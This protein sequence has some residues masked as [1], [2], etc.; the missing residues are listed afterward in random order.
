M[1]KIKRLLAAMLTLVMLLQPF[2]YAASVSEFIDFP[3]DWSSE[4]MTAAVEN[5]LFIGNGNKLIEPGRNL[6]RAELAAL[7]TRAFG[8]TI[9]AD[10]G[11]FDDVN[12]GDWYYNAV[13]KSL[14]MGAMSGTSASTFEPEKS[15]TREE[16]FTV[17]A[18]ILCL[19][20]NDLTVLDRFYDKN[21]ISDWAQPSV[22]GLVANGYIDGYPDGTIQPKANMTRAEVAQLFH[23]LFKT[24]IDASGYHT[25][26]ASEG[27]VIVRVPGAHIE[28]VVINGDLIIADGVGAGEFDLKNVT[29]TGRILVRGGEGKVTFASTTVGNG[30]VV[31]DRN[32]TVNFNNYRTD[33]PFKNYTEYTPATF[34]KK[35]NNVVSGGSSG[36]S[37]GSSSSVTRFNVY[38]YNGDDIY[39]SV[40]VAKGNR[41]AKPKNDPKKTGYTFRYWSTDRYDDGT[42]E[43]FDFDNAI[44]K[45][46]KLYAIYTKDLENYEITFDFG[47][48]TNKKVTITEG[49]KILAADIPVLS[50]KDDKTF[51]GWILPDGKT[52]L[53]NEALAD[54]LFT[55]D[56]VL[57]PWY[58]DKDKAVVTFYNDG[59]VYSTSEV[60]IGSKAEKPSADPTKTGAEFKY[61]AVSADSETA[62]DFA[63]TTVTEALSLHAVYEYTVTFKNGGN[64]KPQKIL[65]GHTASKPADPEKSGYTFKHWS[66]T[67]N[68]DTA[69]D[70]NTK[71][72]DSIDLYAVFTKN[73][74]TTYTVKFVV[75]GNTVKTLSGVA[76]GSTVAAPSVSDK[77][78]AYFA[79]WTIDGENTVDVTTYKITA[80]VEF[81][82]LFKSLLKVNF[83]DLSIKNT[84]I[85]TAYVKKGNA[86]AE[87]Q[88]PHHESNLGESALD[89][90]E[91]GYYKN[92]TIDSVYAG[93][94][95]VHKVPM[96]Y[97]CAD[98]DNNE[99]VPFDKTSLI[100]ADT[101]IYLNIKQMTVYIDA[102][103]LSET[104]A[105]NMY[106]PYDSETRFADT[107]KDILFINAA[108]INRGFDVVGDDFTEKLVN[109]GLIDE[110]G[111]ILNIDRKIALVDVLGKDKISE[112]IWDYVGDNASDDDVEADKQKK[113]YVQQLIDEL[114]A[115]KQV[116]ITAD[117]LFMFE[118]ILNALKAYNFEFIESKIPEKLTKVLPMEH[119]EKL[120][121]RFYDDA[122]YGYV[123]KLSTAMANAEANP[124]ETYYESSAVEIKLNPVS[125]IFV[126]ALEY[127]LDMKTIAEGKFEESYNTY[128]EYYKLNRFAKALE[129]YAD[130]GVWFNGT[131]KGF[132]GK[133]SGYSLKEFSDYYALIEKVS[134]LAD[135]AM[136]YYYNEVPEADRDKVIDAALTKALEIANVFNGVIVDYAE[137]GIP[138]DLEEFIKRIE[139]NPELLEYLEKFG[140]D[141]YLDKIS[142]N[143]TA[144]K[145]YDT[146]LERITAQFGARIEALLEKYAESKLN[147]I[148]GEDEY[149]SA[150][151]FLGGMFTD[152]ADGFTVDT[153][154]DKYFDGADEKSVTFGGIKIKLAR[155]YLTKIPHKE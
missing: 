140:V 37:S 113:A 114:S 134:V 34:L 96:S 108:T 27:S 69:F 150:I 145:V 4:A 84:P 48:G 97:W 99:W 49:E 70:F 79:G 85:Y 15:I 101:D 130:A 125:D 7:V 142:G 153:I 67:E 119:I 57:T 38:F 12:S 87:N 107:I 42:G 51:S 76:Y 68:G 106:A 78:D 23:N 100:N 104:F 3:M 60:V 73:P 86:L 95:Y 64:I 91:N 41:V 18:R 109:A 5:G 105:L 123:T 149:N 31:Y 116:T 141:A 59:K 122:K 62:F 152:E 139:T 30:V 131:D 110:D 98:F 9:T 61:W 46:V 39:D 63:G 148:Y 65:H 21:E 6:K 13:S 26:V 58:V 54:H 103:S 1:K 81:K 126:P 25:Y 92:G 90:G 135:D 151:E 133:L 94:E 2:A 32:G 132:D 155:T 144:D 129:A 143:K 55:S 115:G 138:A 44:N 71:L 29:V 80:D 50:D 74:D 112:L 128:Y 8:V 17:L 120:Y 52:K 124:S 154:F 33:S 16:V 19:E 146:V 24:Y 22:A 35:N 45:T 28:N 111:N 75:D 136:L 102:P 82:A 53:T 36:G 118:P 117:R 56:A 14:Q 147:R 137:N 93:T 20:S 43:G 83:Y 88:Y 127:A 10:I 40:S 47:D 121:S 66:L 89:F 11:H 77:T 72:T